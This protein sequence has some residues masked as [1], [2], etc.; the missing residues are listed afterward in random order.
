VTVPPPHG[1]GQA[2]VLK[3]PHCSHSHASVT[4]DVGMKCTKVNENTRKA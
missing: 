1:A 4:S 3:H 2:V